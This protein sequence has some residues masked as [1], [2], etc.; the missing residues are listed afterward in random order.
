M[1]T[2]LSVKM[3]SRAEKDNLPSTHEL[4]VK[5]QAFDEAAQGFYGTPQTCDIKKFIGAWARARK[6][7]CE[8]T[9]EPLV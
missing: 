3:H 4:H 5:A 7:W 8:Y 9:G 1:N 6:A 2:D